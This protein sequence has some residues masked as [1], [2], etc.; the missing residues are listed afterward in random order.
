[1]YTPECQAAEQECRQEKKPRIQDNRADDVEKEQGAA[2]EELSLIFAEKN[3]NGIDA[4]SMIS[5]DVFEIFDGQGDRISDKEEGEYRERNSVNTAF[6]R[7]SDKACNENK[8]TGECSKNSGENG[9]AFEAERRGGVEPG[10]RLIAEQ[11]QEATKTYDTREDERSD[12]KKNAENLVEFEWYFVLDERP[13]GVGFLIDLHIVTIVGDDRSDPGAFD[14][15]QQD[16]GADDVEEIE[17]RRSL[18]KEEGK[19]HTKEEQA[20][21]VD[22]LREAGVFPEGDEIFRIFSEEKQS[23]EKNSHGSIDAAHFHVEDASEIHEISR[24]NIFRSKEERCDII[25]IDGEKAFLESEDAEGEPGREGAE[26]EKDGV[27]QKRNKERLFDT[28]G[29]EK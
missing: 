7:N 29:F 28:L 13:R 18:G 19:S 8:N 6:R 12:E 17:S 3:R 9:V 11:E 10:Q 24:K 20:A 4:I 22:D 16:E 21:V 2:D 14:C 23:G 26:D 27:R 15:G 1:M 5:F 25:G